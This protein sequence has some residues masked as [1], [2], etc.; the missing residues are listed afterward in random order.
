MGPPGMAAP[1]YFLTG[2]TSSVSGSAVQ[3][4]GQFSFFRRPQFNTRPGATHP[5]VRL[6]GSGVISCIRS[7]NR[8][9]STSREFRS[10]IQTSGTPRSP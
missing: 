9:K 3:S 4:H 7:T 2:M 8:N 1:I 5:T 10:M 6:D